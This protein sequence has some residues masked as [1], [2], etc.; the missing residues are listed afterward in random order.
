MTTAYGEYEA[1]EGVEVP[2]R[3]PAHCPYCGY[4]GVFDGLGRTRS[5]EGCRHHCPACGLAFA[6]YLPE[7]AEVSP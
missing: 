4:G 2:S 3:Q 5:R 6:T 7:G 1:P